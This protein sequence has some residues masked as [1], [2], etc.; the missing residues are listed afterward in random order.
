MLWTR[1]EPT[2]FRP[3]SIPTPLFVGIRRVHCRRDRLRGLLPL[4]P[5]RLLPPDGV[6]ERR[7]ALQDHQGLGGG[8]G[9]QEDSEDRAQGGILR[10]EVGEFKSVF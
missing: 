6:R 7:G 8:G 5:S 10:I 2:N 3:V 4:L 1:S 9:I